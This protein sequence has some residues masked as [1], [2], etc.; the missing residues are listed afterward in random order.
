MRW[1]GS[2]PTRPMRK[3]LGKRFK[4]GRL[5]FHLAP[6]ILARR[7]PATGVPRKMTFGPWMMGVFKMLAK[8]KFLRGTPSIRSA[9][10]PSAGANAHSSANTAERS[11]G[12]CPNS[13]RKIS[14]R[15]RDR[16]DP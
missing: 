3:A 4:G 16:L 13:R 2:I 12:C 11:N 14:L 7:D 8:F 9:A 10:P 5:T 15:R 6:P 1:R